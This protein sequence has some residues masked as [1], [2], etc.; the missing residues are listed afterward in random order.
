MCSS[1]LNREKTVI[2]T[3]V[4]KLPA[5]SGLKKSNIVG[6]CEDSLRRLKTD[7]IDVYYAHCEDPETPQEE[8]MAAF[9]LLVKSGKVRYIGASQHQASSLTS[10]AEISAKKNLVK[11]SI[12]QDEYN[13]MVRDRFELSQAETLKNLG[14]SLIPYFSLAKGFLSG[15]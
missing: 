8:S 11:F 10:A 1:D 6:A 14:I 9:D 5:R 7:Y 3:K 15:K 12:L 2:A 13:L 4:A